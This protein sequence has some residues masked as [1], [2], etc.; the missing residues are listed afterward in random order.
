MKFL[1][2]A[3]FL[4]VFAFL[5]LVK[6]RSQ[7]SRL[8]NN[9]PDSLQLA[10]NEISQLFSLASG[11]VITIKITDQFQLRGILKSTI[12]KY[13][14]LKSLIIE[15]T[16]FKGA[17]LSLA[18]RTEEDNTIVYVGRILSSRHDDGFELRI[19][20]AG[21]YYLRKIEVNNSIME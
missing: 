10:E 9:I 19:N 14:N 21:Q 20:D 6:G 2:K 17:I 5:V 13:D 16:N 15:S 7:S 4:C 12:Q 18:R 3:L 1:V 8:F 11:S